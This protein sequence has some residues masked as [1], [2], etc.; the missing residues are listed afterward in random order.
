M[1]AMALWAS[2][3]RYTVG[4]CMVFNPALFSQPVE[5]IV[6]QVLDVRED[7]YTVKYQHPRFDRPTVFQ[8]L[9]SRW[10]EVTLAVECVNEDNK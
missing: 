5:G 3:F 8:A 2:T 7:I 10:D 4:S 1:M 9:A 6:M